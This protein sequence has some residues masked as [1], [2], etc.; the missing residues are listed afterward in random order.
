MWTPY[1]QHVYLICT[2]RTIPTHGLPND[3]VFVIII[4]YILCTNNQ[5]GRTRADEMGAREHKAQGPARTL[6]KLL[7]IYPALVFFF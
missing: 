4:D 3:L 5:F 7:R 2:G 1:N 6:K